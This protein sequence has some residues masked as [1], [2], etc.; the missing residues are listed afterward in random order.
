MDP[1]TSA[2]LDALERRHLADLTLSEVSRALRALSSCYV[3][4]REKLVSGGPLS[5]AGKR[6]AFALFYGP[7]HFVI[8]QKIVDA[9]KEAGAAGLVPSTLIDLGCGTGAAGAAWAVS[10]GIPAI[11]GFDRNAWA[12][13]E[14]AWTYRHFQ[15][16][17]RA[18][19]RDIG[20]A[21]VLGADQE[22]RRPRG[23]R[24]VLAAYAANELEPAAREALLAS[25]LDAHKAGDRILVVEPIARR[26]LPW[27]SKW[28]AAFLSAGGRTD[29]WRF[30]AEL[31]D[32]ARKLARAAGLDPR[33]LTARSLFL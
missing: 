14:A 31:P 11:Q 29:E 20:S 18:A 24:A 4:R 9:M 12:I 17:G 13:D 32:T 30:P 26:S 15:L 21:N 28:E 25:L 27:W 10:A 5:S 33:E 2:W 8:L 3:E 16:R 6:A 7:Q 22:G 23:G 1:L 19:R